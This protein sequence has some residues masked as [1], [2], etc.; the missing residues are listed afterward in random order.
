MTIAYIDQ[1]KCIGCGVC[2]LSCSVDVIRL[3]KDLK[4]A[5]IK[6][7]EECMMCLMCQVDCKTGAITI[8]SDKVG[9]LVLSW[10]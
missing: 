5:V 4:K 7:A 2:I 1:K 3:D 6:Y 9:N 8:S 10:G